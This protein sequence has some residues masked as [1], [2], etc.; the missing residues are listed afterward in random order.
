[1]LRIGARTE[2]HL[3]ALGLAFPFTSSE[4]TSAFRRCALLAHPD[5]GGDAQ[6]FREV[7]DAHEWLKNLAASDPV[8]NGHH[9]Q[10]GIGLD[11]KVNAKRCDT[12]GGCGYL[13]STGSV[14]LTGRRKPT[15]IQCHECKGAGEV[16][17]YNPVIRKGA[18]KGKR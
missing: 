8:G 7:K 6:K 17:I 16:R 1:M 4:L 9:N 13:D 5:R 11:K 3:A 12:C 18:I 14:W 10:F 2:S 15:R